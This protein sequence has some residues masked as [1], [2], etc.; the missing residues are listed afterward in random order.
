MIFVA[1]GVFVA[2]V[3]LHVVWDASSSL[4]IRVVVA[5]LSFGALMIML[6]AARRVE[7]RSYAG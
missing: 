5:L 6:V 2:V 1:I 7:G 4:I 3:I